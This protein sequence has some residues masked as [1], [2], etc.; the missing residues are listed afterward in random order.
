MAV[1]TAQEKRVIQEMPIDDRLDSCR[2]EIAAYFVSPHASVSST[3][4]ADII[5]S[6][7]RDKGICVLLEDVNHMLIT[8]AI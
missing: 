8:Y 6:A 2:E 7:P 3:T 5:D 4:F 1:L